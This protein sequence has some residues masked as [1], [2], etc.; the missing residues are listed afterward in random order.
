[1]T[2]INRINQN[3]SMLSR[4]SSLSPSLL[5]ELYARTSESL[6]HDLLR[7]DPVLWVNHKLGEHCWSKQ[8]EILYSIRD[9]R[10]TAVQSC[11][12]AG[13]SF[14]AACAALWWL[15]THEIGTAFVVTSASNWSQVRAVLWQEINKAH[16]KSKMFGRCNQ[17][18]MLATNTDGKEI[19]VAIGRKPDDEDYSGFQG[20]HARHVLVILDEACGVSKTL[21]D[22]ADTL[23]SNADSRILAIGNPDDPVTEFADVCK[24][25]SGWNVI[26]VSAFDTPN[27]TNEDVPDKLKYVLVSPI[28]EQEKRRKWGEDNPLYISRVLGKFPEVSTDNALIPWKWIKQAQERDST[29][30][31]TPYTLNELGVDVGGGGN[32]NVIAQRRGPVV[33]IIRK[34][35]VPDTMLTL[36]NVLAELEITRASVAKIDRIGIGKGAS[37]RA[38]QIADDQSLRRDNPSLVLYASRVLGISVADPASD[39]T[40]FVNIR[41]EWYWSLRQRFEVGDGVEGIDIDPNDEDLAAQLVRIK[42]I[43]TSGKVQIEP[44]SKMKPSPD[45]ADAVMLAFG[46]ASGR[47]RVVAVGVASRR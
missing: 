27:F 26:S 30:C 39:P 34:D 7:N 46:A 5:T 19:L 47:R 40:S 8:R 43:P 32:K 2:V 37:D 42:Y 3:T 17:T 41:A 22:A 15:D 28:W 36:D 9:N 12:S 20:I 6:E 24:P 25:G 38:K 4:L 13:K 44:K 29:S 33:R 31:I 16:A 18:E 23:V 21:Y 45:E 10:R 11:N 1:M 35:Q 14:T